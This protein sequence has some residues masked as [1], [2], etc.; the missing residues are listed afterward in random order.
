MTGLLIGS[1]IVYLFLRAAAYTP[2]SDVDGRSTARSHAFWTAV[3]A[4]FASSTAGLHD[5]GTIRQYADYLPEYSPANGG[6]SWWAD[7]GRFLTPAISVAGIYIIGQFTWPR[8]RKPVRTVDLGIRRIRDF[9]PLYLTAVAVFFAGCVGAAAAL[10]APL[11]RV[12]GIRAPQEGMVVPGPVQTQVAGSYLGGILAVTLTVLI[13]AVFLALL[14]ITRRRP[15]ETISIDNDRILRRISMNRLLRTTVL[16]MAGLLVLAAGFVR[17]HHMALLEADP[18]VPFLPVDGGV[19]SNVATAA[20]VLL[21]LTI[22][23]MLAWAPPQLQSGARNPATSAGHAPDPV[24]GHASAEEARL[25]DAERAINVSRTFA[26][27]LIGTLV[28]VG[29]GI[30]VPFVLV[31]WPPAILATAYAAVLLSGEL[32]LRK[33]YGSVS[34]GIE[35]PK[36]TALLETWMKAVLVSSAVAVLTPLAV[37]GIG[38][39]PLDAPGPYAA[40][41]LN[42]VVVTAVGFIAV[43]VVRRRSPVTEIPAGG[44]VYLR[45]ISAHRICRMTAAGLFVSAA[46]LVALYPATWTL[47]LIPQAAYSGPAPVV[48]IVSSVLIAFAVIVVVIPS[49]QRTTRRTQLPVSRSAREHGGSRQ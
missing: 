6:A 42:A 37:V 32:M 17:D 40:S 27:V 26:I 25:A 45:R 49:P 3:I 19:W 44:D 16:L 33:N 24:S 15:L 35:K 39:S 1:V 30:A 31:P 13:I 46:Q 47:L 4:L 41:I 20:S 7:L 48:S 10:L 43:E 18:T 28:L 2:A 8:A 21:L 11:P 36:R 22:L 38:A 14:T 23:G 34:P 29:L 5:V 12:E 9:L